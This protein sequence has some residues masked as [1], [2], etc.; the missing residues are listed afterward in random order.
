MYTCAYAY[1][2]RGISFTALH[3]AARNGTR[4]FVEMFLEWGA[5]I[6]AITDVVCW[7]PLHTA[8]YSGMVCEYVYLFLYIR[9]YDYVAYVCV[10]PSILAIK[11]IICWSSLTL[12]PMRHGLCRYIFIYV[13]VYLGYMCICSVHIYVYL[14]MFMCRYIFISVYVYVSTYSYLCMCMCISRIYVYI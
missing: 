12:L 13:C 6:S 5:N 2:W 3:Y 8:A 1:V 7:T 10:C 14:C 11:G 4:E 9:M